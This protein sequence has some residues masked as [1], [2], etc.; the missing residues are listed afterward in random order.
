MRSAFTIGGSTAQ[1]V[2][3]VNRT[4]NT[5]QALQQGDPLAAAQAYGGTVGKLAKVQQTI[6]PRI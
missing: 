3:Q 4:V 6:A 5:A 2:N 1:A